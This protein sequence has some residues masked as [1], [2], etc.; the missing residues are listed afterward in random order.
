MISSERFLAEIRH[1]F[2]DN[3]TIYL[4]PAD[5]TSENAE[6]IQLVPVSEQ[7]NNN[8]TD[9][10]T[11]TAQDGLISNDDLGRAI[12]W[13]NR[14]ANPDAD[15]SEQAAIGTLST[16]LDERRDL[17]NLFNDLDLIEE[18]LD[19]QLSGIFTA[20]GLRVGEIEGGKNASQGEV[21]DSV[22]DA[23]S[24]QWIADGRP[25]AVPASFARQ[26][27]LISDARMESMIGALG[28]TIGDDQKLSSDIKK[29]LNQDTVGKLY[30]AVLERTPSSGN[31]SFP[32]TDL[33]S[34]LKQAGIPDPD[35]TVNDGKFDKAK[36]AFGFGTLTVRS[37]K[38]VLAVIPYNSRT[39]SIEGR[40]AAALL[41]QLGKRVDTL[42]KTQAVFQE[43]AKQ[44]A[45]VESFVDIRWAD[46]WKDPTSTESTDPPPTDP[47]QPGTADPE[48]SESGG[49][50]SNPQNEQG[51]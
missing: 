31:P 46:P 13:L 8:D 32:V 27:S 20:G 33:P 35:V 3:V 15:S 2:S 38:E 7:N 29:E 44:L 39:Q 50:T 36:S 1:A 9:I 49:G 25:A 14:Y 21:F 47:E 24:E 51:G 23:V 17:S 26:S 41:D 5:T 43:A 6:G 28:K 10:L 34:M 37:G 18:P 12:E 19:E 45:A 22:M 16:F 4:S 30:T 42:T 48:H 11:L 40:G